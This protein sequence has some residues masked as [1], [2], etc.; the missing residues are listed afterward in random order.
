MAAKK[1]RAK[2]AP[3]PRSGFVTEEQRNTER[4]TLRLDPDT[5]ALLRGYA[6]ELGWSLAKVVAESVRAFDREVATED[7]G[8]SMLSEVSSES[9]GLP[10]DTEGR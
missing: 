3:R 8:P 6:A 4:L 2:K 10:T 5:M 9:N 1:K 7:G